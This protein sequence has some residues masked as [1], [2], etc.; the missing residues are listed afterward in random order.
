MKIYKISL[1]T[2]AAGML[3]AS[4][5]DIEDQIP[6]GSEIT[7]E[8]NQNI[9]EEMPER[10]KA[11]YN[12]LFTMM[13][14]P[15]GLYGTHYSSR[16]ADDFGFGMM[17][18]SQDLEG[19]DMSMQDN[20]YNWFSVCGKMTSRTANYANPYTRYVNPYVQIGVANEL[21]NSYPADTQDKTALQYIAVGRAIRAFDYM[22]L[23]PYFGPSYTSEPNALCIPMINDS[24]NAQNNPRATVKQVWDY[25]ESELTW[26]IENLD[27]FD[28]GTDKS[29]LDQQVVYGLRARARLAM[30]KWADAAAD[31]EK[32]MQ[33]YTPASIS[34]VSTPAF[35]DMSKESNWIWGYSMTES[36]CN[37][38]PYA[39]VA[40][41]ISGFS[42]YGYAAATQNTPVINSMLYDKIPDTDVRKGWWLNADLQSPNLEGLEWGTTGVKGQ[43]IPL[44]VDPNGD[45]VEF[46]PYTNVKFGMK[47]GIGS[48][49]N[50]NDWPFMRVEEMILIEAE[51]LAKSGNESQARQVLE[52]FV[53]TYR[54]PSYS[55]TASGRTLADEIWFQRRV[56]LWGEGFFTADMRR[57]N[58]P[59]V[60]FHEGETNNLPEAY[61]FNM[62]A[63]DGWL[64]MR[65][66]QTEMDNNAG[67][68]D[69]KGGSL[70]VAGQNGSLRDGVT[71]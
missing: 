57:L 1:L 41:W 32:A 47:A 69:N 70:P 37:E 19:A 35:C 34:A 9:V 55:S 17:A 15:T 13:V 38:Y 18:L 40:S 60:R 24:V 67:I 31:A 45:K 6:E 42:M 27:G 71:D 65:F 14:K 62:P 23:A 7:K 12:G 61:Q 59:L 48:T 49:T 10:V 63:D 29:K 58:K 33:G 2:L 50:T 22:Q 68:V 36:L 51:G 53:K 56:E 43:D 44:Y 64:N 30:G 46:L 20:N 4:C 28:R 25:I 52:N 5:S 66:P 21:I 26:A 3:A 11:V 54:D 8:Q 16:R 39:T